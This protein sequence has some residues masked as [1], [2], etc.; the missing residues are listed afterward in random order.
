MHNSTPRETGPK[1]RKVE[2]KDLVNAHNIFFYKT[3][4]F[5]KQGNEIGM[6]TV[7]I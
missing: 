7:Q 4:D 3:V 6:W 1:G 2:T 5:R